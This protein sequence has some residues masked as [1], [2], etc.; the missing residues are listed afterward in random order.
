MGRS[1]DKAGTTD[2]PGPLSAF[3]GLYESTLAEQGYAPITRVH[4]R[5]QVVQLS[6]WLEASGLT[7]GDLSVECIGEFVAASRAAGHGRSGQ[8]LRLLLKVLAGQGAPPEGQAVL[9]GSRTEELL[10]SFRAYLDHERGLA[11]STAGAYVERAHRFLEGLPGG[12]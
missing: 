9:A 6:K 1:K 7:V 8:G 3:V 11:A 12:A 4:L 10:L 2:V 5:R